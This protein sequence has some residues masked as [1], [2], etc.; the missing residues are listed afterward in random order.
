MLP[1]ERILAAI[2]QTGPDRAPIDH[3]CF[4]GAFRNHGQRLLDLLERYPDDFGN[5]APLANWR[6]VQKEG[7]HPPETVEWQDGWGTVWVRSSLYTSGEVKQPALPTWDRWPD[8]AFPPTPGEE[9][10]ER[11]AAHVR[12]QH[13]EHF[14][15]VAGGGLF[16]HVQNLRGPE[17][18]FLDI[19]EDRQEL[20]EL[21][22][23]LVDYYLPMLR[24]HLAAGADCARWGD[25]WGA[26]SAMLCS[27][28]AW[29]R[30]FKPRYQ[31]LF[32]VAH[33]YNAVI[34]THSDGWIFEI[35]DDLIAMGV[36]VI[37]PQHP[38]MGTRRVGEQVA[39]RALIRTD[40]DR[41]WV[42]PFGTPDEVRAAVREA[43]EAF[44]QHHGGVMLHG[45]VGPHVPFENIEALYSAFYEYGR[46]PL[47][48]LG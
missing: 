43:I 19:G 2:H 29:R 30:I 6:Q 21:L 28:D 3:Y 35:L 48:W 46:Y 32:D 8:Y 22:D 12:Q 42:M 4:P 24:R 37:N 47:D 1:R 34:W 13:P 20:H 15:F 27:P 40:I 38:C 18:F 44:G 11:F 39:G 7:D 25:D 5:A 41:Q 14:V 26:Q 9:H 31:K 17:G 10:Y 23:R 45:E 36:K 33:E 16:Q